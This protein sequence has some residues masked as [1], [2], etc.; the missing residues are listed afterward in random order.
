M[1]RLERTVRLAV[2]VVLVVAFLP[3]Q[4]AQAGIMYT[5]DEGG[6]NLYW[7]T[8]GNWDVEA[9]APPG[10]LIN[11]NGNADDDVVLANVSG[12]GTTV[13]LGS[14][15]AVDAGS[16]AS[17][18]VGG[19]LSNMTLHLQNGAADQTNPTNL[20][21]SGHVT[22]GGVDL[23]DPLNPVDRWA[24]ITVGNNKNA[25]MTIDGNIYAGSPADN[26]IVVNTTN[27]TVGLTLNGDIDPSDA[28]SLY[29]NNIDLT[30]NRGAFIWTGTLARV[31]ELNIVDTAPGANTTVTNSWTLG[32]GQT[33][34]TGERTDVGRNSA[35]NAVG[36]T[37]AKT[38]VDAT[39]NIYGGTAILNDSEALVIGNV[40]NDPKNTRVWSAIG[41]VN[42]GDPS[43]PAQISTLTLNGEMKVAPSQNDSQTGTQSTT[44]TLNVY[45][46]GSTVTINGGVEMAANGDE[47]GS[48]LAT[49][50]INDGLVT[51]YKHIEDST[52]N[53]S[54]IN[55]N[56]GRLH[57]GTPTVITAPNAANAPRAVD[58]FTMMD[59]ATL[60]MTL[61][62]LALPLTV[63]TTLDLESGGDTGDNARIDLRVAADEIVDTTD[64]VEWDNGAGTGLW[65]ANAANWLPDMLPSQAADPVVNGA[66]YVIIDGTTA[67]AAPGN[68]LANAALVGPDAANWALDIVTN[69]QQLQATRTG[70]TLG[71][72]PATAT[73]S[74]P[75]DVVGRTTD[76]LI[77][78][79]TGYGFDA[80]ALE[81]Y[82]GSL[83]LNDPLD[84]AEPNLI[85]EG[86]ASTARADQDI[87]VAGGALT[88]NGN[89]DF[90]GVPGVGTGGTFRMTGGS[91]TILGA[92]T[93]TSTGGAAQVYIGGGT[94]TVAGDITCKSFRTGDGIGS[95][96]AYTVTNG[97]LL[98]TTGYLVVGASGTGALTMDNGAVVDV[99]SQIRIGEDAT[100]TGTMI[101]NGGYLSNTG[102]T[103]VGMNGVGT[104]EIRA[105]IAHLEGGELRVGTNAGASG[106]LKIGEGGGNPT[107]YVPQTEV[108][109]NGGDGTPSVFEMHSGTW[110]Q[111]SGNF[112]QGQVDGV[113]STATVY[114]GTMD[115]TG[116][117]GTL[118]GQWNINKGIHTATILGGQVLVG[119]AM[120]FTNSA[121]SSLTFTIGDNLGANPLVEIGINDNS[122]IAYRNNGTDTLN[123]RSGTLDLTGGII[124]A[125]T[126]GTNA[127]NWTGGTLKNVSEFQGNLVQDDTDSAS[128]LVIG[129]TPGTMNVTGN[130][131]LSGGDVQMELLVDPNGGGTKGVDWDLLNVTGTA[132]FNSGGKIALDLGSYVPVLD[133]TWDIVDAATITSDYADIADLF[134]TTG[135]DPGTGQSW[136]FSNFTT[137]GTV[138]IVPEPATLALLG[139]GAAASL[140]LRRHRQA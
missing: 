40:A 74:D 93:Y 71:A 8:P 9:T 86:D 29:P 87:L 100:A 13:T 117:L 50:N 92:I 62:G 21:V 67:T 106:T 65:D 127:F 54:I 70:P 4:A 124:D 39:W 64:I 5:W 116:S 52:A 97:Q 33:I 47:V 102:A 110:Y 72:G 11:G 12:S 17:L 78:K 2:A 130:Y 96:G 14:A 26:D 138:K 114:G 63:N 131:T 57:L 125:D 118:T 27:T 99:Q 46:P 122:G 69:P 49:I 90:G 133:D 51:I 76:L 126:T 104:L 134:D 140:V 7:E 48:A 61:S 109:Q 112:V 123:L 89:L 68:N 60:Q 25:T 15:A 3:I 120:Q 75:G 119:G 128:L 81:I 132:A 101:M 79:V 20:T 18:V 91:T 6:G 23:T 45:N 24:Q 31:D 56:G 105:G 135:A 113:Q 85:I 137:D 108:P 121:T 66:N 136:D 37:S 16:I 1:T 95:N 115:L 34:V 73:I 22:L 30:I 36:G 111:E 103:E 42:V 55:L 83:T 41:V 44:G 84:L 129:S 88:I 80:A 43:E 53:T 82:D 139:L 77:G 98:T 35:G 94:L 59:G 32:P 107:V 28:A 19:G 58:T 38:T 10:S